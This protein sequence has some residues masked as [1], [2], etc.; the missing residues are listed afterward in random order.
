MHLDASALCCKIGWSKVDLLAWPEHTCLNS[1]T[2][3]GSDSCDLV[4]VLDRNP[5]GLICWLLR[6]M[7]FIELLKQ[8]LS[9]EPTQFFR[10]FDDVVS[11]PARYGDEGNLVFFEANLLKIFSHLQLDFVESLLTIVNS[12]HVH[13]GDT[14]DHLLDTHGVG[15]QRMFSCLPI[16][17]PPCFKLTLGSRDHQ[18]SGISLRSSSDHVLDKVP[19]TWCI[20]N[21]KGLTFTLEL[22]EANIN[23]NSSFPFILEVVQDPCVL[24]RLLAHLPGL[25]LVLLE[26]SWVNATAL[27]DHVSCGSALARV[28]MADDDQI[29]MTFV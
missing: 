14:T 4:A 15:E 3:H 28:H 9:F 24:E 26:L 27:I 21:S 10:L 8:R 22:P 7:Y 19:M 29:N 18:N 23:R 11:F 12:R 5:E 1:S 16:S 17:T 13:F 2:W 25:F 6:R 20:N